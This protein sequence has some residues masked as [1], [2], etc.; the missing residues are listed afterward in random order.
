MEHVHASLVSIT[1]SD[2]AC[3]GCSDWKMNIQ[4]QNSSKTETEWRQFI[5]REF[6][7]HVRRRHAP[8]GAAQETT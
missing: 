3:S 4:R 2:F 7:D 1:D 6:A 5:E 8:D